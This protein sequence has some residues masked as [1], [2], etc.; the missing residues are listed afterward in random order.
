MKDHII[1]HG[2]K[3]DSYNLKT[4]SPICSCESMHIVMLTAL[5]MKW[6]VECLDFTSVF[7]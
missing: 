3:E 1:V 7:L 5:V 6:R 2:Y 4:D